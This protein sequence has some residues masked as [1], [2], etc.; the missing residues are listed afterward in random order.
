MLLVGIDRP[1]RASHK[2]QTLSCCWW[3]S[4]GP[5]GPPTKL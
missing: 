2:A 3:E 4:I 5:A 1:F